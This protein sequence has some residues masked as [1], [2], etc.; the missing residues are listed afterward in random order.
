MFKTVAISTLALAGVLA[1]DP[2]GTADKCQTCADAG[3]NFCLTGTTTTCYTDDELTTDATLCAEASRV[4]DIYQCAYEGVDNGSDTQCKALKSIKKGDTTTVT[5]IAFA[6]A[7]TPAIFGCKYELP[8]PGDKI[9]VTEEP[10][11]MKVFAYKTD[12]NMEKE[13][14]D[15]VEFTVN[16]AYDTTGKSKSFFFMPTEPTAESSIKVTLNKQNN[17][18]KSAN[19]LSIAASGVA[20]LVAS[21]LSF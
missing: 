20:M 11:N 1:A 5:T 13:I 9:T 6:A 14:G 7:E 21:A 10:V 19:F 12:A 17:D 18:P 3:N 15:E 8:T 4:D 16:T 2:V